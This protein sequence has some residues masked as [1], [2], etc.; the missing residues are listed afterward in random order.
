LTR[1]G[2]LNSTLPSMQEL[3]ANALPVAK[4]AY[5]RAVGLNSG[6]LPKSVRMNFASVVPRMEWS[7][8]VTP[9]V[10]LAIALGG[11]ALAVKVMSLRTAP[12]AEVISVQVLA[13]LEVR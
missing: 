5:G 7:K 4:I 12:S 1:Q 6:L 8:D 11:K 3:L 10:S 9:L 13:G 2:K